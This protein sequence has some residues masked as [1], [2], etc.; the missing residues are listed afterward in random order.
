ME[1]SNP[2]IALFESYLLLKKRWDD[3]ILCK[4]NHFNLYKNYKTISNIYVSILYKIKGRKSKVIRKKNQTPVFNVNRIQVATVHNIGQRQEQQDNI[5]VTDFENIDI[6]REKGFLAVLA[7]GMG[8]INNGAEISS[9]ITEN[10]KEGFYEF[11]SEMPMD[12]QLLTM[13]ARANQKVNLFV[14]QNE[15]GKC[16]STVISVLIKNGLMNFLSVGDSRIYLMRHNSLIQL[17]REQV[18]S[19]KLDILSSRGIITEAD[20]K[21]DPQRSALTSYVGMGEIES[22]DTNISPLRLVPGDEIILM[23]DGVF[24]TLNEEEILK[25]LLVEEIDKSATYLEQAVLSKAKER[26]DNFSAVIIRIG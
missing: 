22:I 9:I 5:L 8:G 23:S 19:R 25:A 10:F 13:L 17:N 26:Q 3:I 11:N 12:M 15:G 2:I 7:D 24:G 18:Y 21:L 6:N 14:S 16:G 1:P 20:A 4:L